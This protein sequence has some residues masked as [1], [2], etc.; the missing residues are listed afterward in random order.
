MNECANARRARGS[1]G[2]GKRCEIAERLACSRRAATREDGSC[3]AADMMKG[4]VKYTDT[5]EIFG[6]A[7]RGYDSQEVIN[8]IALAMRHGITASRLRDEIYT[9]PSMT[10]AFN[11]LLGALS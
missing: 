6:A 11:Q 1:A 3:T 5:D 7:L 8:T 9:H 4:I 2:S 10:E